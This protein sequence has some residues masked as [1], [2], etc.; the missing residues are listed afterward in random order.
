MSKINFQIKDELGFCTRL[1]DGV[2]GMTVTALANFCGTLQHTITQLPNRI[3]DSSSI[4]NELPES[5]KSFAGKEWRLITNYDKNSL[6]VIDELCHAILEYYA[7]DARKYK[8]KQVAINNYRMI[9]RA[10]LR[11]F[12][13]SKT[14]YSPQSMSEEQLVLHNS[15]PIMQEAI[16]QL[17]SQVQKLLSS[18]DDCSY[19]KSN[20]IPP[21]WNKEVWSKL[22]EQDK[23]HFRFL[24]R[25]RGF[26]PNYHTEDESAS[27]ETLT[28]QVKQ[29]Q[30][31]ELKAIVGDVSPKEKARL[32]AAKKEV[33]KR[34]WEEG[35]KH[36]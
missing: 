7:M 26:K 30:R 16:T 12:I 4:T 29:K 11:V 15:I 24:Y 10:G 2:S 13:W 32:E 17:Q 9:A 18:S 23:R 20:Y 31:N 5:L 25:R 22:P 19:K 1:D 14:G 35:E 8:G 33:L 21:G 34:F 28:L 36:E 3:R 6:F 27:M